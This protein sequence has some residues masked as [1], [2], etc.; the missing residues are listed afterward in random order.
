MATTVTQESR[1]L[2]AFGV[3]SSLK[4]LVLYLH[5]I[6]DYIII[7]SIVMT[8]VFRPTCTLKPQ[9]ELDLPMYPDLLQPARERSC[10]GR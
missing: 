2:V 6:R 9:F 3:E 1:S 10:R 5:Q 7:K 8:N 4:C